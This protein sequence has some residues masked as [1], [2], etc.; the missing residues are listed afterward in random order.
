MTSESDSTYS[1]FELS[2]FPKFSSLLAEN[3]SKT[4][5]IILGIDEAGRGPVLGS[6]IYSAAFWPQSEDSSISKLGFN[7]SKQLSENER[8]RLLHQI[9]QH[10][11]IGYVIDEITSQEISKHM[12]RRNP[13]SLNEI[14]YR[15]VVKILQTIHDYLKILSEETSIYHRIT[16]VYVDTVG[17]PEYYKNRLKQGLGAEFEGNFIIEKKADATYRIVSA[18]SI[19][20]KCYRDQSLKDWNCNDEEQLLLS[21]NYGSGYPG[22]EICVNW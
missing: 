13:V 4:I 18:A 22:D 1:S 6:L 2:R 21:K 15:S 14:S 10:P 16:N 11:L 3:T 17:D 20:A 7:D 12:L 19:L 9:T 8:K 5:D